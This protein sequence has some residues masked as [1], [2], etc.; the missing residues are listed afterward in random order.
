MAWPAAARPLTT[1]RIARARQFH[2]E[3]ATPADDE[4]VRRLLREQ[5]L[6]G[7]VTLTLEREPDTAIAGAIEG[8]VH[9]AIVARDA[10]GKIVGIASRAERE[11]FVNGAPARLG[12]LGQLRV[13]ARGRGAAT[14]LD[15]GFEFCRQLHRDGRVAAYLTAIVDDNHA[16]RRLLCGLKSRHAPRFS[17]AGRLVTFAIP[18]RRRRGISRTTGI[19]IDRGSAELLPDIVACLERNGCRYQFAPRWTAADLLSEQRTPALRLDQFLVAS[20]PGGR[21]VGC[22]AVWD[23]RT[24]KQAVVRGYSGRLARWRR[25]LN[26]AAPVVGLPPLPRVGE[27]LEFV[28]L[29]HVAVDDDRADVATALLAEARRRLPPQVACLVT[30]FAD[31]SALAAA[32]A[33]AAPHRTYRSALYLAWW[34]DGGDLAASLDGRPPHPEIAIL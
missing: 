3:L 33:H 22:A 4:E 2:V 32:V 31:G 25:V 17:P 7:E 12:Y 18:G 15:E 19:T 27:A 28:Y 16:A 13:R 1:P 24:F 8:D 21:I 23:Q 11:V 20:T 5:P 26:V 6:P 10:S 9:D 14:L 29:S 30:A 34:P